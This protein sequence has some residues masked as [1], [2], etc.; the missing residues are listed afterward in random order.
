[1]GRPKKAQTPSKQGPPIAFRPG[2]DLA[3]LV[4]SYARSRNVS[5]NEMFKQLAALAAIGLDVRYYDLLAASASLV[6]GPNT[7]AKV[8]LRI[9]AALRAASQLDPKYTREPL[10]T[11]IVVHTVSIQVA[12][13]EGTLPAELVHALL[14]LVGPIEKRPTVV[15]FAPG[16]QE[17]T[18]V[19]HQ[20]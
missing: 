12:E 9:H 2:V 18:V 15:E 8:T 4:A 16:E 11:K 13:A 1:M 20:W 6:H 7:F 19:N 10:R 5:T 14:A 3:Q 17:E